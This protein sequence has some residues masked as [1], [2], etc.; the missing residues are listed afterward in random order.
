[1]KEIVIYQKK[2]SEEKLKKYC[3]LIEEI[4]KNYIHDELFQ[5]TSNRKHIYLTVE[6][7]FLTKLNL[8]L[9]A[10]DTTNYSATATVEKA[11]QNIQ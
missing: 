2:Y 7:G 3:G 4:K 6:N 10:I 8:K 9:E 1:M 11:G 5:G